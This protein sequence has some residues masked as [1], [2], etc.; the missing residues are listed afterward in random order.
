MA[1]AKKRMR[2]KFRQCSRKHIGTTTATQ[3]LMEYK[4]RTMK[5]DKWNRKWTVCRIEKLA[6]NE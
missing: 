6:Q 5:R 2:P 1:R 4:H 3:I